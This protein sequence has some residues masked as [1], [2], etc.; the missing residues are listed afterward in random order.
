LLVPGNKENESQ[1]V[2]E[3]KSQLEW[4]GQEGG[5]WDIKTLQLERGKSLIDK[6]QFERESG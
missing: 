6:A 5:G 3:T 4:G 1:S 2:E